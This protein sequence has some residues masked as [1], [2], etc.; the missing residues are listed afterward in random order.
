MPW[1]YLTKASQVATGALRLNCA[2]DEATATQGSLLE[3]DP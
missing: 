1:S 2:G 3:G